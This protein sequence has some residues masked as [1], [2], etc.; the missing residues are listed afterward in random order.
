MYAAWRVRLAHEHEVVRDPLLTAQPRI[1]F[2]VCA[3]RFVDRVQ[4]LQDHAFATFSDDAI[5]LVLKVFGVEG[6]QGEPL[7]HVYGGP[8]L[9]L[10]VDL[11]H[12]LAPSPEF[13]APE[14]GSPENRN[15]EHMKASEA[16]F[17]H[18]PF[19]G[20]RRGFEFTDQNRPRREGKWLQ[21]QVPKIAPRDR[22][23]LRVSRVQNMRLSLF[24]DL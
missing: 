24:C 18:L 15:V 1:R 23:C 12:G 6:K 16:L 19:G 10:L 2:P 3:L 8:L 4:A 13:H 17:V 9:E 21:V 22:A 7:Q 14:L 11:V 20:L 5:V